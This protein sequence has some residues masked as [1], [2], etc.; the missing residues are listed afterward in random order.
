MVKIALLAPSPIRGSGGV[1]RIYNFASALNDNGYVADIYVSD[2]GGRSE[3]DLREDARRYY[4]V[5]GVHAVAGLKV[6]KTYDLIIAT[7]WDT[8]RVVRDMPA[9]MRTY[10]I[11]NFEACFNPVGDSA[12]YLHRLVDIALFRVL[13]ETKNLT[14]GIVDF[15]CQ[16][17][18]RLQ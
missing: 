12:T 9:K 1:A 11:Q 4:A 14:T 15:G 2:S 7:Q 17:E 6:E 10:F 16:P 18:I 8:A 5:E 13:S 3:S